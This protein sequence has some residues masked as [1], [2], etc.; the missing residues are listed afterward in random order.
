M[1][2][3]TEMGDNSRLIRLGTPRVTCSRS[4]ILVINL[5][6]FHSDNSKNSIIHTFIQVD[7]RCKLYIII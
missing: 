6:R 2:S 7:F 4:A 1:Q 3:Y 5:D